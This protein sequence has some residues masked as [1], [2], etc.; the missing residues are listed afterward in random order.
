MRAV[1][2]LRRPNRATD[3]DIAALADGS[4]PARRRAAVERAVEGSP[5]LQAQLRDQRAALVAVRSLEGDR[6]PS[7]LR[8][9]IARTNPARRPARWAVPL[10]ASAVVG[11]AATVVVAL[12]GGRAEPVGVAD[13]VALGGRP[14]DAPVQAPAPAA[15]TLGRPRGAALSFPNWRDRFGWGATG[16]REDSVDG[17]RATT[18]F[19]RRGDQVVA[20]TIVAGRPL[21]AAP[22]GRLSVR[23]GITFRSLVVDGRRAVSWL[24]GGHTC[25]VS[26]M[27]TDDAALLRLAAWRGDLAQ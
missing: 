11:V 19:Y 13:A 25:V 6:A 24:R 3:R 21:S 4:L 22:N 2:T 9:R 17:R 20:Y 7:A 5:G 23:G 18:V 10:A 14:A 16:T 27:T 15:G 12:G 1:T 26:S 8:A